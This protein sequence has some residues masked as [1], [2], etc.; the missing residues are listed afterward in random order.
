MNQKSSFMNVFLF[1]PLLSVLFFS[2]LFYAIHYL[3]LGYYLN[4]IQQARFYYPV[5]QIY[6]LFGSCSLLIIAF[7]IFVK[8]KNLDY[9][10]NCFMLLTMLKIGIACVF[11]YKINHN[12]HPYLFFEKISFFASF[13]LF[14]AIETL[15][16]VRLLNKKQ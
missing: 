8:T 2:I 1:K 15:I 7:L 10:G 9:V 12:N 3:S 4:E 14:L 5:F 13:I 6:F 11:L 16:T